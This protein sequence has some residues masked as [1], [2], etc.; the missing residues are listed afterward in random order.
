MERVMIS[1]NWNKE[2]RND[3]IELY[4]VDPVNDS[5]SRLKA[6]LKGW[7]RYL[8]N[9]APAE[10]SSISWEGLGVVYASSLGQIEENL[11]IGI[12]RVLLSQYLATNQMNHWSDEKRKEALEL[13]EDL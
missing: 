5:R 2:N 12:Y 13:M 6:F 3:D 9:N 8:N 1:I 7:T 11:K 4:L 10:I